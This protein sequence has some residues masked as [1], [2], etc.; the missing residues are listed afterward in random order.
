VA[1]LH[2]IAWSGVKR[3]LLEENSAMRAN[4][5]RGGLW[6]TLNYMKM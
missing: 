3:L 5:Q 4:R 6:D 2:E 1:F